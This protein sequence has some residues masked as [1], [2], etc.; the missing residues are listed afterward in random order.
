MGKMTR[1]LALAGP[2]TKRR[3]E[4]LVSVSGGRHES[5]EKAPPK[6]GYVEGGLAA[7][8]SRQAHALNST[9]GCTVQPV[10]S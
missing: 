7:C 3:A 1:A 2:L 10:K 9:V 6:R 8:D 5:H 4:P